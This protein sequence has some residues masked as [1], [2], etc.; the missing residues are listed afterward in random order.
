MS[1]RGRSS[2][3]RLS[4]SRSSDG[5]NS[6][7][8]SNLVR[9]GVTPFF[10]HSLA[11]YCHRSVNRNGRAIQGRR[12]GG[13]G[14]QGIR[15]CRLRLRP[16]RPSLHFPAEWRQRARG[17]GV[18]LRARRIVREH[19]ITH[20]DDK[21]RPAPPGRRH[22]LVDRPHD[23]GCLGYISCRRTRVCG[24]RNRANMWQ[25]RPV[26]TP[27]TRLTGPLQTRCGCADRA[28]RRCRTR[29]A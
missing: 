8:A 12:Q 20:P 24:P 19:E 27:A 6:P 29:L 15:G 3:G 2:R 11:R 18:G 7:L 4:P 28:V 1:H 16:Q 13:D 10:T 17:D 5:A 26:G 21:D 9:K 23:N 22:A 14:P 25:G